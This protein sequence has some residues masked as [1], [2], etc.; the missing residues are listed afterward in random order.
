MDRACVRGGA[1]LVGEPGAVRRPG[2]LLAAT[3]LAL[4]DEL[5]AVFLQIG[6]QHLAAMVGDRGELA[7]RRG[8][9][10]YYAPDVGIERALDA[11]GIKV[12]PF[13]AGRVAH[14]D[15]AAVGEPASMA[16]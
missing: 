1:E 4:R 16:E 9:H 12:Q 2:E 14:R 5:H 7:A 6:E 15:Q 8:F 3:E 11:V 13:F 10:R